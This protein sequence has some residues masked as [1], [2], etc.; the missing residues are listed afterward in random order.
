MPEWTPDR[1]AVPRGRWHHKWRL[2]PRR[3]RDSRE[4]RSTGGYCGQMTCRDP[5]QRAAAFLAPAWRNL[6]QPRAAGCLRISQIGWL[7]AGGGEGETAKATGCSAL[8][9]G[10]ERWTMGWTRHE[11]HQRAAAALE[12]TYAAVQPGGGRRKG[13]SQLQRCAS[14]GWTQAQKWTCARRLA[15]PR[16][17]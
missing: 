1:P 16:S 3:R 4:Q 11:G 6:C 14:S 7:A 8:N 9:A 15:T 12:R 17:R 2:G 13:S 10:C 5:T